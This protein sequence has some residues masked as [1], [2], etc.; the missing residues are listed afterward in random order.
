MGA[1]TAVRTVGVRRALLGIA[2]LAALSC[3]RAARSTTSTAL[4]GKVSNTL[5]KVSEISLGF[6]PRSS[7]QWLGEDEL[8]V[9]DKQESQVVVLDPARGVARRIGR[10]GMGPGEFNA[11]SEATSLP[12]G[13]LAVA[14]QMTRSILYIDAAGRE[15]RRVALPGIPRQLR[16]DSSGAVWIA[17][18]VLQPG[19]GLFAGRVEPGSD[20]VST[21]F[22]PSDVDTAYTFTAATMGSMTQL[23][24][25]LGIDGKCALGDGR[26]YRL[27]VFDRHT[28]LR[29]F[30]RQDLGVQPRSPR[31]TAA[32]HEKFVIL[33]K[34]A[35]AYPEAVKALRDLESSELERPREYF[36]ASAIRFDPLG[37]VWVARRMPSGTETEFDRYDGT[38]AFLGTLTVPGLVLSFAL[39]PGKL[40]VLLDGPEDEPEAARLVV[41]S[42]ST[43]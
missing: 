22:K 29:A 26:L 27:F 6:E 31:E 18:L 41:Y 38:G 37:G 33:N 24:V 1:S 5:A 12:G 25:D 11:P 34:G 15:T 40:A 14:D 2:A 16:G 7:M 23:D 42:V 32:I 4:E 28:G 13:L 21:Y 17:Y 20:S 36:R 8:L 35:A 10:K 30:G 3:D 9:I 43:L 19:G 39:R